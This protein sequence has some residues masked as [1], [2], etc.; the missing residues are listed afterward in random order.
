MNWTLQVAPDAYDL[1]GT[2]HDEANEMLAA[3]GFDPLPRG[4]LNLLYRSV[5]PH[6]QTLVTMPAEQ[7][8]RRYGVGRLR[9]QEIDQW[10]TQ[11]LQLTGPDAEVMSTA[12][13]VV[14]N[15]MR[16]KAAGEASTAELVAAVRE[17]SHTEHLREL[18]LELAL[19]VP[20]HLGGAT[21]QWLLEV[22]RG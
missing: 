22:A 19:L 9:F 20:H 3:A 21:R 4:T 16:R 2:T 17:G 8:A 14:V 6:V 10:R 12:E 1:G 15:L 7:L 5:G 13:R 11:L 18:L